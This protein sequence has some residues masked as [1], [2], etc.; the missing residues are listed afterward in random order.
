M[1][2]AGS[3]ATSDEP[4]IMTAAPPSQSEAPAEKATMTTRS[5]GRPSLYREEYA[6]QARKLCLLGATDQELAEFFEIDVRT[7]YDWK[8]TKPEFSQAIAR[9]K[10]LAD[11]E[12]AAKLYERACGYTHGAIKI[13]RADDGS[14]IKVP[15]TVEYPPDTT[16]ASL[17]LRNRQPRLWR[18]KHEID[19]ADAGESL[20]DGMTDEELIQRVMLRRGA[21]HRKPS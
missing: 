8:R 6:K 7:V 4:W 16:A 17:W 3:E 20:M 18:D 11:A 21:T 10:M 5:R 13:Y 19:V 12:V 2:I 14:V 1:P 15:Y 9:G